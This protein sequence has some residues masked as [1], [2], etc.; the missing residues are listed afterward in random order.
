VTARPRSGPIIR[1]NTNSGAARLGLALVLAL[2]GCGAGEVDDGRGG[3]VEG[4]LTVNRPANLAP[5]VP[6]TTYKVGSLVSFKGGVFSC[7]Q[8][9]TAV[10]GWFPDLAVVRQF[11]FAGIIKGF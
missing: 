8:A 4:K 10:D 6:G 5:W 11:G 7:R 2:A 1:R 3:A 9:H